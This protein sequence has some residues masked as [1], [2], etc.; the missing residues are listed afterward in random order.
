[1]IDHEIHLV[2]RYLSYLKSKIG[3]SFKLR[4]WISANFQY[5]LVGP[6]AS[7]NSESVRE[8]EGKK[9]DRKIAFDDHTCL[10]VHHVMIQNTASSHNFSPRTPRN[11]L[12]AINLSLMPPGKAF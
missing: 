1:M 2:R 3:N 6:V 9:L 5:K 10:L 8:A 7:L 4:E 12:S 11:C